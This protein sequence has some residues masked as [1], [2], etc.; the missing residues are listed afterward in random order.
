MLFFLPRNELCLKIVIAAFCFGYIFFKLISNNKLRYP[1]VC[2]QVIALLQPAVLWASL[3]LQTSYT[4][5]GAN[6]CNDF[7]DGVSSFFFF[8]FWKILVLISYLHM[9]L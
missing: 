7:S 9:H 8:F 6:V 5:D 3:H 4:T 1:N 2:L